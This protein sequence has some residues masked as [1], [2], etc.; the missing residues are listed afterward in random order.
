MS[1]RLKIEPGDYV[2]WD[3]ALVRQM[4][5]A[6]EDEWAKLWAKLIDEALSVEEESS[7]ANQLQSQ[8][9]AGKGEDETR[10]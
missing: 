4:F 5:A 1:S 10:D 2:S 7:A 3:P 8:Q 9:K 6:T